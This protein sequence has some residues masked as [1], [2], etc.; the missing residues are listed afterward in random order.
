MTLP[1]FVEFSEAVWHRPPFPWQ[2]R[3][4]ETVL[5]AGWEHLLLE[6]PTGA[7]KT[8]ALDVALYCLAVAPE[9]MP[10]RTVLVVDRRV[11]VD[12]AAEH[13]RELLRALTDAEA[14]P[15]AEIARALRGVYT[16]A[17]EAAPFRIALMR[18]GMPRDNDWARWPHQ[19]VLASSTVDQLG[20]RLLF[21][22]YGINRMSA[23]IHAGLIGNDTLVL[24]DEVHLARPFATT[25]HQIEHTFSHRGEHDKCTIPRR[26]FVVPMSATP[27]VVS[28]QTRRF[29]LDD[30]DH[31][32]EV[33][34]RRLEAHKPAKLSLIKLTGDDEHK[35]LEEIANRAVDEALALQKSGLRIVGVIVNRVETAQRAYRSLA[36]EHS[37]RTGALLL[38]GRMRPLERDLLVQELLKRTRGGRDRGQDKPLIVV[39][40]QCIE[41]GADLDLD[42]I[43]TECASL[44]ALRQRFG[45]VDRR[46][47][48]RDSRSVILGRS[49]A[50]DDD[51]VY[52]A[53]LPQTWE[54]LTAE[55][56]NS[57]VDFGIR[58]LPACT[59]PRVL[60]DHVEAPVLLPAHLDAWAQ[61]SLEI[62]PDPDVA[63]W[64]HGPTRPGADVQIVWRDLQG[65][66]TGSSELDSLSDE[67][68]KDYLEAIR[69]SSIEAV[70][71]P[72][73]AARRWL[74]GEALEPYADVTA[75]AADADLPPRRA[76]T[77]ARPAWSW[78]GTRAT[79]I[80][81]VPRRNSDAD[82]E[83]TGRKLRPGDVIVVDCAAGGIR[84]GA[85]DPEATDEVPDLGEVAQLRS[86]GIA[87]LTLTERGLHRWKIDAAGN[88]L[89]PEADE[90]EG[91]FRRRVLDLIAGPSVDK[92]VTALPSDDDRALLR[93]TFE[94]RM[95]LAKVGAY[96]VSTGRVTRATSQEDFIAYEAITESDDSSFQ[97]GEISLDQHS[98]D[99]Q[100]FVRQFG[101]SLHVA[102]E[103]LDDLALAAW[104]HDV[105]KADPRFQSWL[106][107]GDDLRASVLERPL[108]KSSLDAGS[109]KRR[110][111]ARKRARYPEGYRHELLSLAM[112]A[113]DEHALAKAHDPE[114]VKHLVASHHGWCRPFAAPVDD[115]D[116]L[117]VELSHGE[118]RL[119]A[120]TRHHLGQLDSG[121]IDRFWELTRRYGWWGLAWL[122]A[123]VRLADH[124]ASEAADN[125]RSGR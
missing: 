77:Q 14:G 37:K 84:V 54:W 79:R 43:V 125:E 58:W 81:A 103:L 47:D 6:L 10:R 115:P 49:D 59:N 64:L 38:T 82:T 74:L 86:R 31:K 99:V 80:D 9:R 61:T 88:S 70:S 107:G 110:A 45:R 56:T 85:F 42:G 62:R 13:A 53:A 100:K 32:D 117:V 92:E 44:D 24:L 95:Q 112:I 124:R 23:S 52:G 50:S 17:E 114:L 123:L 122:E 39:A 87:T 121:V 106:L 119:Q 75:D 109:A 18:G 102:P 40:T 65:L 35:K 91:E 48:F 118:T 7:G 29:G 1:S 76:F 78:D 2:R 28:E 16:D 113:R 27:P 30:E 96:F 20:S 71:V 8:S 111:D 116:D 93:R 66:L 68:V 3:L 83:Y 25:L 104:L 73:A 12:Q 60:P 69:P 57:T 108:A 41:A 22:G 90:S 72:L 67:V 4:A 55:S 120:T 98:S 15:A 33:L 51:P 36:T 105:G 11:V 46:G 5:D 97:G 21:R 19:P 34:Q 26:F 94:R 63:L 101:N 89:Q